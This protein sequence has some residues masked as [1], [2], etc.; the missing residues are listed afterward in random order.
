M[1]ETELHIY[2]IRQQLCIHELSVFW[3]INLSKQQLL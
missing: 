1:M 3:R 2:V